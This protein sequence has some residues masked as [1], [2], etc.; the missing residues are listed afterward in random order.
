MGHGAFITVNVQVTR[1][2]ALN[3]I[4]QRLIT[5]F[6]C[7]FEAASRNQGACLGDGYLEAEIDQL[8]EA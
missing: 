8:E 5:V 2:E 7:P 6:G 1:V 4:D 3:H